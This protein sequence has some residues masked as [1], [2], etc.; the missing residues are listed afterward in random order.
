MKLKSMTDFVLE[1]DKLILKQ[2]ID[3]ITFT[4]RATDYALFLNQPLKLRM[5]VPCDK[6]DNVFEIPIFEYK[7]ENLKY[8]KGME[9]LIAEETNKRV[10]QYQNAEENVIFEDWELNQKDISK[11]ENI[12]FISKDKIQ[13]TFFKKEK[14]IFLDNFYNNETFEI[15]T[16]E[17]LI[18][19]KLQIN[20]Q[21]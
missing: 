3:A 10:L 18:P 15:K 19:Y 4:M 7:K 21:F 11:L 13:L 8:L 12:I 14:S 2:K 1:Q 20:K 17:D 6:D 9:L 5:F 16:I